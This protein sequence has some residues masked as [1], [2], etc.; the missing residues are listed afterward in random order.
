MFDNGDVRVIGSDLNC[1]F[2]GEW[3][4]SSALVERLDGVRSGCCCD[5]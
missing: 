3:K 4:R 1:C 2:F 5:C